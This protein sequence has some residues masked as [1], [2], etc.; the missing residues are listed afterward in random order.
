MKKRELG[1]LF[2]LCSCSVLSLASSEG[3]WQNKNYQQWTEKDAQAMMSA[4]PWSKQMPF[5]A[6]GRPAMTVIESA[7]NMSATPSASLGNTSNPTND[8]NLAGA[9]NNSPLAATD[10]RS[11]RGLPT[12]T[13]PSGVPPSAGAPDPRTPITVTW[14]SAV[15]VRLAVLKIRSG[16][17]TPTEAEIENA[18]KPRERYVLAVI[19]LPAPGNYDTNPKELANHAFLSLKGKTPVRALDSDYRKIGNADVYFFRFERS[20]LPLSISDGGVEFKMQMGQIE[21]KSHFDLK[22]M[23]YAGQLAL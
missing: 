8:S 6:S 12:N 23:Q 21:I 2:L 1:F 18:Q 19:G 11:A 5:P 9:A 14:A 22:A 10:P 17:N 3:F 15:P 20:S 13:T 16:S 7:A 4:S